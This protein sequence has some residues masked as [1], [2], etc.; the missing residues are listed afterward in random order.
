[1]L[2]KYYY[3]CGIRFTK[4][5]ICI[6]DPDLARIRF[7]PYVENVRPLFNEEF[8]TLKFSST[9]ICINND[10]FNNSIKPLIISSKTEKLNAISIHN[11]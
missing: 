2:T 8:S 9:P 6:G 1:M 5:T 4:D 11:L 7:D 3:T 10:I